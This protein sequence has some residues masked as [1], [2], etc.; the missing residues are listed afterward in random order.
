MLCD[1]ETSY[2]ILKKNI[3][4]YENIIDNITVSIP[5]GA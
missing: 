3:D 5:V 4:E 1:N 2:D